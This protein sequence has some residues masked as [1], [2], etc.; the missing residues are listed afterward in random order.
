MHIHASVK[1]DDHVR[2]YIITRQVFFASAER[3]GNVFEYK[4]AIEKVII[5]V[6]HAHFWDITAIS[7]LDK[8]VVKFRREG[9]EV[10]VVDLNEVS[11]TMVDKFA[12]HDMAEA[13]EKDL[14]TGH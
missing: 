1:T 3:F 14:L 4:E 13:E 6:I 9:I 11:A 8:V 5:D 10:E 2:T 7:Q 12:I